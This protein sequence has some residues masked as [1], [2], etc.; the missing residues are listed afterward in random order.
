MII[1]CTYNF[2]ENDFGIVSLIW[3][4]ARQIASASWWTSYA[5]CLPTGGGNTRC[6]RICKRFTSLLLYN[7]KT[8]LHENSHRPST[9]FPHTVL[10]CLAG[11]GGGKY[12]VHRHQLI[13][14][15]PPQKLSVVWLSLSLL[16]SNTVRIFCDS[17]LRMSAIK[18][19]LSTSQDKDL[20]EDA[21]GRRAE[22]TDTEDE[23]KHK[24]IY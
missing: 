10:L 6:I 12:T 1:F 22:K 23:G 9:N 24:Y 2:H 4:R 3:H 11:A 21:S 8:R 14:N 19:H 5:P 18:F 13:R 15:I 16:H 20:D 7:F 17:W